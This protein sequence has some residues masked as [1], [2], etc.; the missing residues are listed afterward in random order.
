MSLAM[1]YLVWFKE[2][3]ICD[4]YRY[5]TAVNFYCQHNLSILCRSR[6]LFTFIN[7]EVSVSNKQYLSFENVSVFLKKIKYFIE[8]YSL[9]CL[10][11][12]IYLTQSIAMP[13]CLFE[14][15]N[16]FFL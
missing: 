7:V 5:F 8:F 16:F 1:L 3:K 13:F 11:G 2:W 4:S 10:V 15:I 6:T 12:M 9:K 14:E